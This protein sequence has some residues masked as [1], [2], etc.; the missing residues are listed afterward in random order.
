MFSDTYFVTSHGLWRGV[1]CV[2][3]VLHSPD[4]SIFGCIVPG[5][6]GQECSAPEGFNP[7]KKH[8]LVLPVHMDFP[9]FVPGALRLL[10]HSLLL[11]CTSRSY[12]YGWTCTTV[13]LI[14]FRKFPHFLSKASTFSPVIRIS[15]VFL[16][17][18]YSRVRLDSIDFYCFPSLSKVL[19]IFLGAFFK[20][21]GR[22]QCPPIDQLSGFSFVKSW[23]FHLELVTFFHCDLLNIDAQHRWTLGVRLREEFE[24]LYFKSLLI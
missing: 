16:F 13:F 3:F 11:L 5:E 24:K 20:L 21:F 18:I 14:S 1:S 10:C 8:V 17:T 6:T 15:S 19:K 7:W 23:L 22:E 2:S 12:V 9:W 4:S